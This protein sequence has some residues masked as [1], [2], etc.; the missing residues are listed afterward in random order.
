[1][2]QDLR[3]VVARDV[4]VRIGQGQQHTRRRGRNQAAAR[5]QHCDARAFRSHERLSYVKIGLGQ[6][7]VEV[8]AGDAARNPRVLLA[9]LLSVAVS[10]VPK[11]CVDLTARA[12][13]PDGLCEFL[14]AGSPDAQLVPFVSNDFQLVDIVRRLACHYRMHAAGIVADV[15]ADR[16]AVLGGRVRSKGQPVAEGRATQAVVDHPRLHPSVLLVRIQLEDMVHVPGEIQHYRDVA[17]LPGQ[18]GARAAS[19]HRRT[20][21]ATNRKGADHIVLVARDH[22]ADGHLPVIGSVGGVEGPAP[23]VETN[24]PTNPRLQSGAQRPACSFVNGGHSL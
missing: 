19:Q 2:R 8:V 11:L 20:E 7:L 15:A 23:L 6:Q 9:D 17:A 16:A 10:Q 12:A 5:G 3:H 1:V 18:T 21:F 13:N 4:Y 14:L 24:F 22:H